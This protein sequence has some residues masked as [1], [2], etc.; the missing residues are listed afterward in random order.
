MSRT[1]HVL[2][3]QSDQRHYGGHLGCCQRSG[4]VSWRGAEL[5]G[6]VPLGR[7]VHVDQPGAARLHDIAVDKG[8][9]TP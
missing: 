3:A 6:F 1:D 9:A 4:R 8:T 5:D 2:D 7:H